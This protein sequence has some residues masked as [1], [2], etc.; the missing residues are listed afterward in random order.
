MGRTKK[1]K[2][3]SIE[4]IPVEEIEKKYV[5]QRLILYQRDLEKLLGRTLDA[6]GVYFNH[7]GGGIYW[8]SHGSDPRVYYYYLGCIE[9]LKK[10]Q[11]SQEMFAAIDYYFEKY[12]VEVE[13]GSSIE[14]I[15]KELFL[16]LDNDMKMKTIVYMDSLLSEKDNIKNCY[17]K[18][19][20]AC[21]WKN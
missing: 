20:K 13:D 16:Q 7:S 21:N 2:T 19:M 5:N 9:L 10:L 18:I 11:A 3:I 17:Q 4:K 1:F 15:A 8:N 14:N 6:T 12:N